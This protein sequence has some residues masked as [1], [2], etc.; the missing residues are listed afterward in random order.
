MSELHDFNQGVISEFRANHGK[1]GGQLATMPVL[2]LTTTGAKSGRALTRPLVY[3]T[4]GDRLF[5]RRPQEST[6][7][8]QLSC[9]PRGDDRTGKRTLLGQGHGYVWRGAPAAVQPPSRTDT[10]FCRV[11]AKDRSADT[12]SRA[13]AD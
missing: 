1:V 8:P 11:S 7:V 12:G 3:T 9:Q 2:L 6:L 4:D 10:D 13:H 5:R